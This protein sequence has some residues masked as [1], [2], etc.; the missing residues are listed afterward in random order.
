MLA[1]IYSFAVITKL[2]AGLIVAAR[3]VRFIALLAL[4]SAYLQ[5]GL[6]KVM[7]FNNAIAEANLF[8]LPCAELIAGLTVFTELV[9]PAL[10]LSGIYRWV[11]TFWL[12][13]FTL[14][15]SFIANR[16]WEI[17]RPDQFAVENAFLEHI[18]L[19][20]AFVLVAHI[21]LRQ[22]LARHH[23]LTCRSQARGLS[24]RFFNPRHRA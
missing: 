18:G 20:G 11:G 7:D 6:T 24:L 4:C 13:G 10:V 8:G 14:M 17:A 23:V 2:Y 16:Y 5:G 1:R 15:A 12:A 3:V 21:D 22:K 19:V 9:A